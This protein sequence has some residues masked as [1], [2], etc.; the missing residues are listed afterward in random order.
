MPGKR[1]TVRRVQCPGTRILARAGVKPVGEK[2]EKTEVKVESAA[3][4]DPL[5]LSE[6]DTSYECDTDV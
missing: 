6:S 2:G 5:L 1:R 4:S 3:W